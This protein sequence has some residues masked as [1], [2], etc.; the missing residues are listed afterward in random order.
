M[1]NKNKS[2]W[3]IDTGATNH[4]CSNI[5]LFD[6]TTPLSQVKIV[7]L[8]DGSSQNVTHTGAITLLPN[9]TLTNILFLPNFTCNLLSVSSLVKNSKD[10][11]YFLP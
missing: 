1:H 10:F 11:S 8:P 3:I 7:H 2:S 5:L 4:M 6:K 9:F